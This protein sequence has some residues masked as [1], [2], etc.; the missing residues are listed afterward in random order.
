MLMPQL[1]YAVSPETGEVACTASLVPTFDAVAPQDLFE[2][3]K[4]KARVGK[5][6][7]GF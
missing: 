1:L 7:L 2:V 5:T 6:W 3:V 4:M